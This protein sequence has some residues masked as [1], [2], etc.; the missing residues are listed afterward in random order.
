M[1][2]VG[3]FYAMRVYHLTRENTDIDEG[4]RLMK[5]LT[6]LRWLTLLVCSVVWMGISVAQ[7]D[8]L[9]PPDAEPDM[10]LGAQ[11]YAENCTSCHGMTGAGDGE[12]VQSGQLTV[13]VADFTDPATMSDQTPTDYYEMVTNGNLA[14]LMPPFSR[15][16]TDFERWSVANYVYNAPSN[17]IE[18]IEPVAPAPTAARD[19]VTVPSDS[20]FSHGGGDAENV[21]IVMGT[22]SGQVQHGTAGYG[23]PSNMTVTLTIV[24]HQMQQREI[25]QQ[26]AEDGTYAFIDVPITVNTALFVSTQYAGIDFNSAL[27]A[28]NPDEPNTTLDL[29]VYESSNEAALIQLNFVLTQADVY[30]DGIRL[31]QQYSFTNLS[32][33]LFATTTPDGQRVSVQVPIPAGAQFAADN[34]LER[35]VADTSAGIV[36]DTRPILPQQDHQF[37]VVFTIPVTPE[38][39]VAQTFAYPLSGAFEVY[40]VEG[41]ASLL[42]NGWETL[43]GQAVEEMSYQGQGGRMNVPAG[44][45]ISYTIRNDMLQTNS[46]MVWLSRVLLVVGIGLIVLSGVLFV[47]NGRKPSDND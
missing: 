47:V 39:E 37:Q 27:H 2:N 5:Q 19:D 13:A 33:E 16:L 23:L 21:E 3:D 26:V 24:D 34:D 1:T 42:T 41:Q 10:E 11:I 32:D 44:E 18:Q 22:I 4:S 35:L 40:A 46:V 17:P 31:V 9:T 20:G 12:L 28:G 29:T 14:A 6:G 15:T 45:T 36:Y 30:D 25:E 7:T 38:F 8:D 43:D